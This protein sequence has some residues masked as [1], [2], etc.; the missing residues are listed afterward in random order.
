MIK[1]LQT[2]L[3]GDERSCLFIYRPDGEIIASII[4]NKLGDLILT[5]DQQHSLVGETGM[6]VPL[7]SDDPDTLAKAKSLIRLSQ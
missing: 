1:F 7:S 6:L 2:A 4:K 3:S 5:A